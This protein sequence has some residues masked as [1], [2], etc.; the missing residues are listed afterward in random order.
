MNRVVRW[1]AAILTIPVTLALAAQPAW[2]ASSAPLRTAVANLPVATEVRT[3]YDRDLFPHWIDADGDR[4]NTR[5]EVLIAEATAAPSVGTPCTLTGGRWYSY[6]DNAY[7][8]EPADLDIDHFVPLAE[9]WDSGARSWTTTTR[10]AFA[11]DLGD[12]RSLAAVTDNVNQAKG[13]RDPGTW[14]PP[15][16]GARCRYIADWVAVKTRWRLTVDSTEKQALTGHANRCANVTVTVTQA[17]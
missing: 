8:T 6:Y 13:D 17:R 2:A 7:W 12:R 15:Y 5:Y 9:A 10:R 3:G 11:N 14:M 1:T 4:C 16:S